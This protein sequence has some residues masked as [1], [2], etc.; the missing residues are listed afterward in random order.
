MVR[1]L[2]SLLISRAAFTDSAPYHRK[3][4]QNETDDSEKKQIA[5][6]LFISPRTVDTHRAH[7]MQ[8]LELGSRAELVRYAIAHG[9]LHENEA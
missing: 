6:M 4:T 1:L 7:I 9:L 3:R 8:K 2:T 5:T